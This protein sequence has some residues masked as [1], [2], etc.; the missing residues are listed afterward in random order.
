MRRQLLDEY[1]VAH[2]ILLPR[3]FCN[4]HPDPDFGAA[5]AAAFND[6]LAETW[7][8]KY[9]HDGVFKG[10]ITVA[11]QDPQRRPS[12]RSSAGPATRTSSR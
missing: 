11:H 7:L 12:R 5:I 10:S 8:D 4:L 6:W 1:G 3:A 2:A 9:N